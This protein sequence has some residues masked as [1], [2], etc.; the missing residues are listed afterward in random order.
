MNEQRTPNR[1]NLK[2]ETKRM[3][4]ALVGELLGT[5]FLVFIAAGIQ[6]IS[7]PVPD[8]TIA[9]AV[10]SVLGEVAFV[11]QRWAHTQTRM[12]HQSTV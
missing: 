1:A 7:R 2:P 10:P 9:L 5:M 12:V 4:A 6:V 3:I 8:V 11:G